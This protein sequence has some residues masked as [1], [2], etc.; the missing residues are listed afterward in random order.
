VHRTHG[1]VIAVR[2]G[3]DRAAPRRLPPSP[4]LVA[5]RHLRRVGKDCLVSFETGVFAALA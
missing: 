3:R 4:Y 2:A 5:E 1:E